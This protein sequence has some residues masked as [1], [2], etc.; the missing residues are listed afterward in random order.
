M[1]HLIFAA[2]FTL[3]TISRNSHRTATMQ[4]SDD[5]QVTC[6]LHWESNESS[7]GLKEEAIQA[8][9]SAFAQGEEKNTRKTETGE[10]KTKTDFLGTGSN[11]RSNYCNQRALASTSDTSPSRLYFDLVPSREMPFQHYLFTAY[12]TYLVTIATVAWEGWAEGLYLGAGVA[13]EGEGGGGGRRMR[14]VGRM[15]PS[16]R[17]SPRHL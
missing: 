14:A 17:I 15:P 12:Q 5:R 7:L 2:T 16:R 3:V 6:H 9:C 11:Q 8:A 13:R 4:T 1:Y 10:L